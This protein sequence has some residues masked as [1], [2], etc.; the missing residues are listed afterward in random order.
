MST[1]SLPPQLPIDSEDASASLSLADV[2]A[3]SSCRSLP[4][5]GS[6][7]SDP[8]GISNRSIQSD[9]YT[10]AFSATDVPVQPELAVQISTDSIMKAGTPEKPNT[11]R[12]SP[13]HML[14][15]VS[16]LVLTV[17]LIVGISVG[18]AV[19]NKNEKD[20]QSNVGNPS[21]STPVNERPMYDTIVSY[22]VSQ[23]VSDETALQTEGT[24]QYSAARWL[25]E[26]DEAR[27]Q[28][29][30]VPITDASNPSGYRFI[31]RY[32]MALNYFAWGGDGWRTSLR[33]L[34]KH[35]VCDWNGDK[36]AFNNRGQLHI[37]GGGVWCDTN[38]LPIYLDLGTSAL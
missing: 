34:T 11:K 28:V 31:T 26:Q 32:I 12:R 20:A 4:F 17:A 23:G 29:P 8:N 21:T 7:D 14:L 15:I 13:L 24:P 25:S 9:P 5:A 22:L 36:F 33:F 19:S 38:N 10:D 35:D 27:V 1:P 6:P 37:E 16:L 18:V 3:P 2:S 30:T